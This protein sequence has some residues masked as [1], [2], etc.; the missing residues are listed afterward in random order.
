MYT[1]HIILCSNVISEDSH[2]MGLFF[3]NLAFISG[4][5]IPGSCINVYTSNAYAL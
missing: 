4:E 5:A 2:I 3:S 1:P